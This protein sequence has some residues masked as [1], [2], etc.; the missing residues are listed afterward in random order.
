MDR[1]R[2]FRA[3][4]HSS[5]L[6]HPRRRAGRPSRGDAWTPCVCSATA[7]SEGQSGLQVGEGI[8]RTEDSYE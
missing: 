1:R 7:D 8:F 5:V 6:R 2:V 3:R 4:A